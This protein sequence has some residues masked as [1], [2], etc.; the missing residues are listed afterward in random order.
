[1]LRPATHEERVSGAVLIVALKR[2]LPVFLW[3]LK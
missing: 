1:M 3:N 2:K